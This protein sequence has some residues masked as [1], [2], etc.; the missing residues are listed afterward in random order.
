MAG[1]DWLRLADADAVAAYAAR[2]ICEAAAEAIAARGAFRLVL[3]GGGTPEAAYRLLT[4]CVT[5]WRKWWVY[6]G[7]ERCLPPD[8]DA[9][10]SRMVAR[11]WLDAVPI[12][13][14]N[15][16]PIP[17]ELGPAR[18]AALYAGLIAARRPFDLVLLGL[19]EDGH[20]ASLFPGR[21]EAE[22]ALTVAVD[23]APKPPAERVS[24]S[25]AALR[26]SRATLV[27]VTG[28]RKRDAVSRWR[29]GEA[30]PVRR[31]LSAHS[32]VLADA[33]ALPD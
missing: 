11:A 24:L 29:A 4:A 22:E 13:A 5:D 30:L 26:D 27:L 32:L 8:D 33:A 12:P 18:G 19:G 3:A 31:A 25:A 1:P 10:N 14:D 7:D 20:T 15:V 23:D 9:R 21:V 17:A 2:R 28:A 16:Y 6:Y